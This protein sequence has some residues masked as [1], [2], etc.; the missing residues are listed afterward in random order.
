MWKKQYQVIS[1]FQGE[2]KLPP[3]FMDKLK[4]SPLSHVSTGYD[5]IASLVPVGPKGDN[6]LMILIA[7]KT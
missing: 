7:I 5:K 4:L 6:L 2:M 3:L 1:T